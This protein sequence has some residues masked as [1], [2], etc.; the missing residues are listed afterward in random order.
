TPTHPSPLWGGVRG[1]GTAGRIALAALATVLLATPAIADPAPLQPMEIRSTPIAHFR[2]GTRE[3][4]FGPLEFAGG[5][6]MTSSGRHFGG[7]SGIAFVTPG[8]DFVGVADTGFWLHGRVERDAEGRPSGISGFSMQPMV[9]AGGNEIEDKFDSD[10]E[11]IDIVGRRVTA[12]FERA[13]RI[14]EFELTEAGI[15]EPG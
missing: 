14:V 7:L 11:G 3:T 1:G 13:H 12:S 5:L 15:G 4:R 10:A 9:D 2:I 8:A 6:S